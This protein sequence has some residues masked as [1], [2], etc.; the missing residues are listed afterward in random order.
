[1]SN[2]TTL[3]IAAEITGNNQ[4]DLGNYKFQL[5]M[6][7][8]F[9]ANIGKKVTAILFFGINKELTVR[10]NKRNYDMPLRPFLNIQV[11]PCQEDAKDSQPAQEQTN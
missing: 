9:V 10:L 7:N 8:P 3:K 2:Q 4:I 6:R 5:P 1:M 11:T